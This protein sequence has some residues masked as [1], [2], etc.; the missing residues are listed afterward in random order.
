MVVRPTC[1]LYSD[2]G[3]LWITKAPISPCRFTVLLPPTCQRTLLLA[4]VKPIYRLP[5]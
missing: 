3:V 2:Q 5:L 4:A 1:R